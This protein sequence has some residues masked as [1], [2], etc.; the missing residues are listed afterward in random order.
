[1]SSAIGIS[2][3]PIA[4]GNRAESAAERV[5][6]AKGICS[7]VHSSALFLP[8]VWFDWTIAPRFRDT[9]AAFHAR[10]FFLK[11]QWLLLLF[12][13]HFSR[14]SLVLNSYL[15]NQHVAPEVT[16]FTE[17]LEKLLSILPASF[18]VLD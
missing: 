18:L 4:T 1:M 9:N 6:E 17:R 12:R 11:L 14:V 7:R 13:Q 15:S 10:P 5:V 8:S 2:I 3:R 16:C